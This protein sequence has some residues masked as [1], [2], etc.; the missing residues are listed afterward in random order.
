[1]GNEE[2]RVREGPQSAVDQ[3]LEPPTRLRRDDWIA[4][5]TVSSLSD[6]YR[7]Q[8]CKLAARVQESSGS[9]GSVD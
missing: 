7:Q 3:P 6:R 8:R 1:M 5:E 4:A 2:G 9:S